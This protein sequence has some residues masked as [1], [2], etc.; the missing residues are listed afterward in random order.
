MAKVQAHDVV[1]DSYSGPDRRRGGIL[2]RLERAVIF[3]VRSRWIAM[4]MVAFAVSWSFHV[5]EGH[6]DAKL[7]RQQNINVCVIKSV[8]EQQRIIPHGQR[9]SVG[10]IL[11]RCEKL[12]GN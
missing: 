1:S 11:T 10:A 8:A 5:V 12:E 9:V 2:G 6:A 4:F 7:E 3:A